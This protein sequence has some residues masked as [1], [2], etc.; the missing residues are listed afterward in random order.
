M[1]GVRFVWFCD[2]REIELHKSKVLVTQFPEHP[3][4]MTKMIAGISLTFY[5]GSLR[6][7]AG[8]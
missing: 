4:D 8:R 5:I 3:Y 2:L 1:L 6:C 7:F